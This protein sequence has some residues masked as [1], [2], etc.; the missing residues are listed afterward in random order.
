MRRSA[1]KIISSLFRLDYPFWKQYIADNFAESFFETFMAQKG[2]EKIFQNEAIN[3][4]ERQTIINEIKLK[5]PKHA[6]EIDNT[7]LFIATFTSI[8]IQFEFEIKESLSINYNNSQLLFFYCLGMYVNENP[9][10]IGIAKRILILIA[11]K[12]LVNDLESLNYRLSFEPS[13]SIYLKNKMNL[14]KLYKIAVKYGVLVEKYEDICFGSEYIQSIITDSKYPELHM[15]LKDQEFELGLQKG[16]IY[17][18]Y[19]LRNRKKDKQGEVHSFY[20]CYLCKSC[21]LS[22]VSSDTKALALELLGRQFSQMNRVDL[23]YFY[24]SSFS[25]IILSIVSLIYAELVKLI[26]CTRKLLLLVKKDFIHKEMMWGNQI[27]EVDFD[28]CYRTVLMN[29]T[30][31]TLFA[32]IGDDVLIGRWQYDHDFSI[33]ETVK[34][35]TFDASKSD[36]AGENANRFG[37]DVFEN[38]IRASLD[39]YGWKVL[40]YSIKIKNNG[41]IVTDLDLIAYNQG[42]VMLG[43]IKMANCGRSRYDIWKTKQTINKAVEQINLSMSRVNDDD[44][45][46]YSALKEQGFVTKNTNIKRII[47]VVITSSN[48]FMEIAKDS[49]VSVISYDMLCETMY[50]ACESESIQI[51]E[52]ALTDPCSLFEFIG[53]EEKVISRIILDEYKIFYEEFEF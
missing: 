7:Y 14:E 24:T 41:K 16:V 25:S 39:D 37:K 13:E 21:C 33:L 44:S 19:V 51:V 4:N 36:K 52:K 42:I 9:D 31:Q 15:A 40:P 23:L 5:F 50:H 6:D 12:C 53:I 26:F 48:Y 8:I 11:K 32:V 18:E 2:L 49:N 3:S 20:E 1:S 30:I 29:K 22:L 47:P 27:S 46:V 38:L 34:A 45:L 43:Q 28:M 17:H 35:I 10:M